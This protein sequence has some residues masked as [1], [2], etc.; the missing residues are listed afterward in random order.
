MDIKTGN[1]EPKNHNRTTQKTK[2]KSIRT[3]KHTNEDVVSG[4]NALSI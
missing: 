4:T 1:L 3:G 2:L